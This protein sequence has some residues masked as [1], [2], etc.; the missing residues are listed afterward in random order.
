MSRL[1]FIR[2]GRP[3]ALDS[4]A[5]RSRT[6]TAGNGP[7]LRIRMRAVRKTESV[8]ILGKSRVAQTDKA[9]V[10]VVKPRTGPN[11]TTLART[12]AA[13]HRLHAT[14]RLPRAGLPG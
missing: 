2:G 4:S 1:E 3:V 7:S 6:V 8:K 5:P 13:S 11:A 10:S 9:M 12:Y 14:A